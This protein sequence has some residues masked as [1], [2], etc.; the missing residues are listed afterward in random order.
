MPR[1]GCC[2]RCSQTWLSFTTKGTLLNTCSACWIASQ[3]L[4]CE[5]LAASGCRYFRK[6]SPIIKGNCRLKLSPPVFQTVRDQS[7]RFTKQVS[8]KCSCLVVFI[9]FARPNIFVSSKTTYAN[10]QETPLPHSAVSVRYRSEHHIQHS[11]YVVLP[12]RKTVISSKCYGSNRQKQI[13]QMV[14]RCS[15]NDNDS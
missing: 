3:A 12:A 6:D 13:S 10:C 14:N 2:Q 9:E 8:Y 11:V 7:T 1:K 4:R 15:F 5:C